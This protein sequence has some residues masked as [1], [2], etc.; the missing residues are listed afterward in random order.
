M[1]KRERI[2]A[3]LRRQEVDQIPLSLWRH[4]F[5][6]DR[7]AQALAA[8][9]VGLAREYDLDLVKL[10]PCGLYA[11]EDWAQGL[12]TYP[13]ND[14]D[15]PSLQ[16]PAVLG[17]TDWRRLPSLEPT[18]GALGRE[19]EA[20][21]LVAE[22][23]SSEIPFLMTVFSP[24][25][26]AFKLA[27]ERVIAHLREH[28]ADLHAGLETI[29][30]TTARFA[31]AALEAGA[32]GLFFATQLACHG[33]L[34]PSEYETFGQRYD[35][36]VLDAVSGQSEVTVLHLHGREIFFDLANRYPI[37]AV[38]WHDQ[39]TPP[40]LA[41]AYQ[42]TDRAFLTG[43]DRELLAK[44][45]ASAIQDQVR[46][47]LAHTRRRGLILAPSCVI[48]PTAPDGHLQA[49]REALQTRTRDGSVDAGRA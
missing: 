14:Y 40:T 41:Q 6:E 43:L 20:A 24:L 35:L 31:Q 47:A 42:Q 16:S 48:P 21:R 37:H 10:T 23:L 3:A 33:W 1:D 39:E 44:G 17:P 15:P 5:C 2:Q 38:S 29:A 18:A 4:F 9:T 19:L 36:E 46:Q 28:P 11:V 45:P 12:I 30:T 25:T 26:L 27:G 32:D 22:S 7:R 34:K 49:V 13:G 8:A